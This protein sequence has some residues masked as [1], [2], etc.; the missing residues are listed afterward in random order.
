VKHKL[1]CSEVGKE[2][3]Y[4]VLFSALEEI[5]EAEIPRVSVAVGDERE[6]SEEKTKVRQAGQIRR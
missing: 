1:A 3:E 5:V 6:V 4:L 2:L